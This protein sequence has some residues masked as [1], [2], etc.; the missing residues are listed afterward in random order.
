MARPVMMVQATRAPT[1]SI[2]L[3]DPVDAE[4]HHADR[5]QVLRQRREV[6]AE[7]RQEARAHRRAG[8]DADDSC[9]Q[10]RC[11]RPSAPMLL[12]VSR[13]LMLS[14]STPCFCAAS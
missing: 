14:T 10:W 13:P 8:G 9:S 1:V 7:R 6:D 5:D 12:M 11:M 2:A 4:D 3:A